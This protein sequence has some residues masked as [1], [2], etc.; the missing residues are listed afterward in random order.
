MFKMKSTINQ[1]KFIRD[2]AKAWQKFSQWLLGA[3]Q[4]CQRLQR[5]PT[6]VLVSKHPQQGH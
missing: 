6:G 5:A 1:A 3:M 2:Q 4:T